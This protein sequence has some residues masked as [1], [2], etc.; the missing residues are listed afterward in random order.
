MVH[1]VI[2]KYA[3]VTED[4]LSRAANWRGFFDEMF[5][6]VIERY[7]CVTGDPLKLSMEKIWLMKRGEIIFVRYRGDFC[8]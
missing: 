7:T 5:N 2:G 6:Y 4:P 8:N 1:C 3:C